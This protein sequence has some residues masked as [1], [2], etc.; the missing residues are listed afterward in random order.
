MNP[1]DELGL[2]RCASEAEITAAHRTAVK[3]HHPDRG[4]D[5]DRFDRVQRATQI[6][7]DPGRR[8][9]FDDTGEADESP[10]SLH[11]RMV[12]SAAREALMGVIQGSGDLR[13]VDVVGLAITAA[14]NA[15]ARL[16]AQNDSLDRNLQRLAEV[17]RRLRRPDAGEDMLAAMFVREEADL[18]QRKP[19]VARAIRAQEGAL[20]VLR[21]YAYSIDLNGRSATISRDG[22]ALN[23]TLV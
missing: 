18:L 10:G 20:E 6:L 22:D 1:Y 16:R 13:Q 17:R 3:A 8:Q 19:Q 11:E 15:V 23:I 12:M 2:G 14:E 4:G 9:H 7:R 21:S 5:R